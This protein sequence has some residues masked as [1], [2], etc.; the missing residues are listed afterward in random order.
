ME[1]P[2]EKQDIYDV[3][4]RVGMFW[5]IGYG[6]VRL[7]FGFSLLHLVGTPLSDLFFKA[8]SRELIEDPSDIFIRLSEAILQHQ[9]LTV[10]YFLAA[11]FMFWGLV[12][13]ALS[14]QVLRKKLWAFPLSMT[15]IGLFVLYEVYR[16]THTHSYILAVVIV[17]DIMLIW[18]IHKEYERHLQQHSPCI[19]SV[20]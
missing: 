4:F 17:F 11:H 2:P 3:L 13:I 7:V 6:A 14:V 9:S 15:L 1:R 20:H 8:L 5:R 10:T 19:E 18:L 12:D 16:L